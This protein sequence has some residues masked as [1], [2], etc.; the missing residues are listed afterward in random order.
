V[1]VCCAGARQCPA[2]RL[3]DS[4]DPGQA[5]RQGTLTSQQRAAAII[6]PVVPLYL[7]NRSINV[8]NLN[9]GK[10]GWRWPPRVCASSSSSGKWAAP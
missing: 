10:G 5:V 8:D 3:E 2:G 7:S 4:W 6:A 9:A 1:W